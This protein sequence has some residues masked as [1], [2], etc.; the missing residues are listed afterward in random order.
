[1]LIELGDAFDF[2]GAEFW[3][4]CQPVACVAMKFCRWQA[5]AAPPIAYE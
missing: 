5:H 3:N 4:W 2:T 1:M